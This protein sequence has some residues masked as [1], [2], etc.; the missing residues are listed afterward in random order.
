MPDRASDCP[1]GDF[2]KAL[3]EAGIRCILIG[4]MAAIRQGAPLMTSI[5]ISGFGCPSGNTFGFSRSSKSRVVPFSRG[6]FTNSG[7][8]PR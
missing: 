4:S 5:T 6:R 8:A 1:L 7:T 3:R 2:L